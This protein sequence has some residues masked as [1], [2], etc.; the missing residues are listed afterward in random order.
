[1]TKFLVIAGTTQEANHWIRN[2]C[3]K[4]Y[5]AGDT[6]VSLSD[7]TYVL[8][9]DRIRGRLNPHGRFVGN[10]RGRPDI[11]DIIQA[12]ISCTMPANP[13]LINL[14]NEINN[15]PAPV[16][17]T[18]KKYAGMSHTQVII[19]ELAED[20]SKYIDNEVMANLTKK[21]NGGVI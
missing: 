13:T 7:Y 2:D 3:D 5:A 6:N 21:I 15:Q 17:P 18:P 9:A 14:F 19:D 1:M 16:R 12:L 8:S 20:L 10:W 4:R 11:L